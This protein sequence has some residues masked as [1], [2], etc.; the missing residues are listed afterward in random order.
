LKKK[1]KLNFSKLLICILSKFL[2]S[3]IKTKMQGAEGV[4]KVSR[5]CKNVSESN[6]KLL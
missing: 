4:E 2:V 6:S 3:E 1:I 5:M